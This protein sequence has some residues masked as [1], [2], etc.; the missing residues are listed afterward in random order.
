MTI[1][2]NPNTLASELIDFNANIDSGQTF[3]RDTIHLFCSPLFVRA[4]Q[5]LF[6]K[7]IKTIS[8]GSGRE[9]NILPGITCDYQ[10]LSKENKAIAKNLLISPTEF[11]IGAKIDDTTTLAMFERGL[12][13][14]VN[15]FLPQSS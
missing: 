2:Y 4:M 15:T 13:K 10:S 11:R 14:I 12:L 6:D 9:R 3:G 5:V 1:N 7:N 8:C